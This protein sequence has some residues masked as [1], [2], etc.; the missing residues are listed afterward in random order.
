VKI[1]KPRRIHRVEPIKNPVPSKSPPAQ[2]E[3]PVE[4]KK[5]PAK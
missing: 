4:P 2:P 3:Q 5:L 1:G